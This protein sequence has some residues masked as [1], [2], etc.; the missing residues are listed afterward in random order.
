[1]LKSGLHSCVG[2]AILTEA[3]LS[4]EGTI[5]IPLVL[6]LLRLLLVKLLLKLTLWNK[7]ISQLT[8]K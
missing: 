3:S 4:Q 7:N 6:L 1:M 8:E 5:L 2:S